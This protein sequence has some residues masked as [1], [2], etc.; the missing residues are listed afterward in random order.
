MGY[1]LLACVLRA[2]GDGQTPLN[3]MIL[4]SLINII[5]DLIFVLIFRWGIAGAAI[6]TLIA[7]FVSGIFCILRLS[8]IDFMRLG[9]EHYCIDFSL[10]RR[11][12]GLGMPMASQNAIIAIGGMTIQGVVNGYG[13][14][15]MGGF[16]AANK[17]YGV[18]EIAASSY[19]YAMI[20]YT[21]QNL[22]ANRIDRIRYG[23]RSATI[24][25]IATSLLISIVMIV[26]GKPIVGAFISGPPQ[27][28][29]EA[30]RV[31]YIYLAIMSICLP[32]LYI[33]HVTRSSLQG[34]G[35]T[36][37][38]MVSG[39]V[40]LIMRISGVVILPVLIGENGIFIAEVL[41][42]VGADMILIPSY[43]ITLKKV[44]KI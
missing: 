33:L 25:S 35:N 21:G 39:I 37:L 13:V 34:L 1:N 2:L 23:V 3:A 44:S 18:L 26:L 16:T 31:G 27:E 42:W 10:S 8:K 29:I 5:L 41:A 9:K 19:G 6:A 7:Q 38:P 14:A 30:T 4:A 40:E 17:L 15:F 32:V 22:G 28:I 11:L 43:F 36:I 20:T 12:L 24:I